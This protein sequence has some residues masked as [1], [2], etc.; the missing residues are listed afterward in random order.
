[1]L[2]R[3]GRLAM[4]P[5]SR[6]FA[7]QQLSDVTFFAWDVAPM[8]RKRSMMVHFNARA[9]IIPVNAREQD[10][11]WRFVAFIEG[12]ET[13][14]KS[15]GT[16]SSAPGRKSVAE[17]PEYLDSYMPRATNKLFIDIVAKGQA[18]TLPGTPAWPDIN[19]LLGQQI[20][21]VQ[22]GERT[23]ATFVKDMVP[24]VNPLLKTA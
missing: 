19:T 10:A 2:F 7:L 13:K 8:P 15:V 6:F 3:T 1:V 21:A 5:S 14:R 18:C 4:M 17:S 9:T 20:G 16:G 11:A 23:A 24:Q 12:K 22:R